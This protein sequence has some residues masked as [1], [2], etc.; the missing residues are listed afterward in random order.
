VDGRSLLVPVDW[1]TRQVLVVDKPLRWD[2][3]PCTIPIN[4]P[5]TPT[6]LKEQVIPPAQQSERR[7]TSGLPPPPESLRRRSR[8][9]SSPGKS[10]A[11]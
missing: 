8:V 1:T 6:C 3:V 4:P 11:M 7:R 2:L 10:R 5:V 9:H